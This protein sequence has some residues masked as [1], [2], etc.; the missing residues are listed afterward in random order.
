MLTLVPQKETTLDWLTS[1]VNSPDY[2][3]SLEL[4]M[5]TG[6]LDAALEKRIIEYVI[7][8]PVAKVQTELTG[9]DGQSLFNPD[10]CTPDVLKTRAAALAKLIA[11]A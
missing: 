4:R 10:T 3:R 6:T 7:G 2:R 8:V 5:T 1:L 9:K 11:S